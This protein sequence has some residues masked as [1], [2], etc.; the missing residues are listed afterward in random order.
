MIAPMKKA[1]LVLRE[2]G[3]SAALKSLR[4]LGVVHADPIEGRGQS[5]EAASEE[6]ARFD[7]AIGILLSYKTKETAPALDYQAALELARK[8]TDTAELIKSAQE[9]IAALRKEMERIRGWG[10]SILKPW[11][12]C[13]NKVWIFT[14]TK[15]VRRR[16]PRCRRTCR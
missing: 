9:R 16:S 6:L 5:W 2:R 4:R 15:P 1:I 10:T 12:T 8:V 13:G 11:P 14:S 7:A 3:K